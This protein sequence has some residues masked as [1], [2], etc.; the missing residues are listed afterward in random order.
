MLNEK[1]P[2][3]LYYQLIEIFINKIKTNEWPYNSK[4]PSERELCESYGVS[5]ITVRQALSELEKAGYLYRKQGKGSFVTIPKIEQR[6]ASFYSFSEEIR[7][8]GFTPSTK[9]L[10]FKLVDPDDDVEYHLKTVEKVY[11]IRRL[12]LANNE[13]F[14]IEISY[15]PEQVCPNMLLEEIL[16]DGLYKT[17]KFKYNLK[18]NEAIE[19]FEAILINRDEAI[20]LDVNKNS[21]GFLLHRDTYSDGRVVEYCKGV[22]RGDRYRYQVVLK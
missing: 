22:I 15:I 11:H 7:K 14:A 6:L 10:E 4:I 9:V 2:T 16:T 8:M 19:T 18:P 13:P 3:S 21:P 17:M 12:R 20:N 5:R 1:S